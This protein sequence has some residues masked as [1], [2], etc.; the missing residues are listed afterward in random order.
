MLSF[1]SKVL[2]RSIRAFHSSKSFKRL[3]QI[4]KELPLTTVFNFEKMKNIKR[5]ISDIDVEMESPLKKKQKLNDITLNTKN[6]DKQN[7]GDIILMNK[8]KEMEKKYYNNGCKYIIGTDEAGRGPLAGPVVVAA[9]YIPLNIKITKIADSKA[10]TEIERE[11]LYELIT[12]NKDIIYAVSIIDHKTIDD[13]NILAASL[14]GMR[15]SCKE[16]NTKMIKQLGYGTDMIFVDGNRDPKFVEPKGIKSECII[17][18][19]SKV[20]CIATASIIA[21]VVR[22]RIM[23]EYDKKYPIYKF[24]QHKG[25]PTPY[26]KSIVIEKGPCDIHRCSFNPVKQWCIDNDFDR[27]PQRIKD[28][29]N[30]KLKKQTKNKTKIKGKTAKKGNI[31]SFF[32]KNNKN[33]SKNDDIIMDNNDKENISDK[34]IKKIRKKKEDYSDLERLIHKNWY[35]ILNKQKEFQQEYW[36]QLKKKLNNEKARILP[37]KNEI[38]KVFELC[39]NIDDIKCVLL[40]SDPSH[41]DGVSEGLSFSVKKGEYLTQTMKNIY[42]ELQ[43]DIKFK[44]PNHGSLIEWCNEGIFLLNMVL[45]VNDVKPNSH[46]K[47]GWEYFTDNIIKIIS[48][49]NNGCVFI[50]LGKQAQT[51]INL[52]DTNKH[53][54]ISSSHPSGFSAHRG[55]FGSKIFSKTNKILKELGKNKINWNISYDNNITDNDILNDIKINKNANFKSKKKRKKDNSDSDDETDID[56]SDDDIKYDY[57]DDSDDDYQPHISSKKIKSKKNIKNNKGLDYSKSKSNK[58]TFKRKIKGNNDDCLIDSDDDDDI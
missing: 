13:M 17:K 23:M 58:H 34:D 26:H 22:D 42:K 54:I 14:K 7:N 57:S 11:Q 40:G 38:F 4:R 15:D 19:D 21:K 36:I 47:Y 3:H 45:T 28:D 25:Y 27:L 5:K 16:L 24:A 50:L 18:G 44:I 2:A 35:D 53:K 30:K 49:Y 39:N 52:I 9:C 43:N 6:K 20:Y 10:L 56:M 55:F 33:K 37:V 46:R 1:P 32:I 41:Y 48:K 51:K 8:M 12:T 31:E 29:I